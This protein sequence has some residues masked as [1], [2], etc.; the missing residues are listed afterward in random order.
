MHHLHLFVLFARYVIGFVMAP[1][2][3]AF[4][5]HCSQTDF[6][7]RMER[8]SLEY[9]FEYKYNYHRNSCTPSLKI[10]IKSKFNLFVDLLTGK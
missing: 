6:E 5:V 10:R 4:N 8:S 2:K 3:V 7:I 1:I 9:L